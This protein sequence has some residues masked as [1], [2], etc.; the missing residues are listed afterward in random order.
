MIAPYFLPRRRVGALRP[1][2]FAIH[3][4]KFGWNPHVLSIKAR[5]HLTQKEKKFL[6]AISVFELSTPLDRTNQ[7]GSQQSGES[8]SKNGVQATVA[9]WIDKHFPVDTWLPFFHLKWGVIRKI[10]QKVEPDAVW[11]TGDPWSAHWVGKKIK[12]Q[13]PDMGWI[14][15]F[16]DPW[17]V[18]DMRLKRRS[19]FANKVDQWLEQKWIKKASLLTFT[20]DQTRKNYEQYYGNL[21]LQTATLYNAFDRDLFGTLNPKPGLEVDEDKLNLLFFGRFRR[22]SSARATIRILAR[23]KQLRP[24]AANRI[25]IHVFGPLPE[26]DRQFAR[27]KQVHGCF[28]IHDPVPVEQGLQVMR[29]A[30]LLFLSTNP[31][32]TDIIPAKLWDYLAAER[33]ILSI[34][35]NSEIAQ[36]LEETG[37]GVQFEGSKIERIAE[38]LMECIRAKRNQERIPVAVRPDRDKIRQYSAE[39]STSKLA[40]MLDKYTE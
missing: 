18:S 26:S 2:K 25:A 21:D 32:R 3:L 4:R 31:S 22:L 9:N 15:D 13:H 6:D 19:A 17:T 24:S 28:E 34:A 14:A 37:T 38:L 10:V 23:L 29:E 8:T 33:P 39:A 35:P 27:K 7:S 12:E 11:S 36:I 1:F 40:H 5:G 16:R 30:D 20:S